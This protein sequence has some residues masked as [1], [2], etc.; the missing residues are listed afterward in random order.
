MRLNCGELRESHIDSEIELYGWCR[1]RRDHGGKL[2]I[3]IADRYGTT[4]LV[5]E[6]G[7]KDNAS[8]IGREYVLHVAGTVR[9]R[10]QETIDE[11]NPTGRVEIYVSSLEVISKS[12]VPP[13]EIIEE[14][15][16]FL[17]N[18]DLRLRY[19][20]L[21]LRRREMIDRVEFRDR[22]AKIT[23]RFFWENGFLELETPTMVKDTYET[24]SRTFLVPSRTNPG[25][26][27]SLPQS[28][29]VY[30][31]LCMIS[32]LD[33]Y[34][35]I[36]R[37][38]RDEDPR[39]DRQPEF[40][41][42]D[43]EVSF[44]DEKYIKDLVERFIQRLMKELLGKDIKTP[45]RCML[46]DEAMLKYG[47][48]KPDLRFDNRIVDITEELRS[49]EYN[50]IRRVIEENGRVKA[51]AFGAGYGSGSPL[52]DKGYMLKSIEY[53]KTLG[54]KGLTWLYVEQGIVKSEP[55]SIADSLGESKD[56]IRAKLGAQEG[57]VIIICSDTS[58]KILLDAMG[59]LRKA[60]GE[61][62]GR[63]GSEYEFL[64][65]EGFPLFEKDEIT[66]TLKPSHNPFTSPT[67][68]SE[69]MIDSEPE[70]VMS[71]Q[72]DLVLNGAELGSGSIRIN[73]AE[74]QKEMLHLMGM[75]DKSIEETFGFLLEALRYGAPMHGGI[76]L[77]FDRFVA[78]L[79]NSGEMRDFI[80][81]PKNKRY[82]SPLDG[83]PTPIDQKRLKEDFGIN[84]G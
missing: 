70:K 8:G 69:G 63:F 24:G 41:Q 39:E 67:P 15:K 65:I 17:A 32:G 18:E 13:F 3:D 6:G 49:S 71:R 44:R 62:I 80:L 73:D 31:Q 2:F 72:Y 34:F 5:F 64:W 29:Q 47:S 40:T 84:V 56:A 53:A 55:Q 22:F 37:A 21:D 9:K 11:T 27:Y 68:E 43:L 1:Y 16:R 57:D 20:Y 35:Q 58:E 82:E 59:K 30:K 76:G 78:L 46:Y 33:K 75:S 26:F 42:I 36:A 4:Q 23:R 28:P 25:K 38:Y 7:V 10:D 51:A 61:K 79:Y 60:F 48:D 54:L 52:L 45:F 74:L 77:G 14:K 66:G 19:R 50:I 81:F 83:S 12:E